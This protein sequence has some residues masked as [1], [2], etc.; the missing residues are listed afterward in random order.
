MEAQAIHR[1][2]QVDENE[3]TKTATIER[4]S[5]LRLKMSDF[6]KVVRGKGVKSEKAAAVAEIET[7]FDIW[8]VLIRDLP[9]GL[10]RPVRLLPDSLSQPIF[11]YKRTGNVG[12]RLVVKMGEEEMVYIVINGSIKIIFRKDGGGVIECRKRGEKK[13]KIKVTIPLLRKCIFHA[14]IYRFSGPRY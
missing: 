5:V 12:R 1:Q 3:F 6:F 10:M 8:E 9:V 14:G 13:L 11:Q 2:T 7:E 4:G